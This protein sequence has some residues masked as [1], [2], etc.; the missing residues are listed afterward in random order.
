[1]LNRK[2]LALNTLRSIHKTVGNNHNKSNN[3]FWKKKKKEL[4]MENLKAELLENLKVKL[5]LQELVLQ[6]LQGY[7]Y[8]GLGQSNIR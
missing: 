3:I 8:C 2:V 5:Y 1:M 7:K 4:N 6:H